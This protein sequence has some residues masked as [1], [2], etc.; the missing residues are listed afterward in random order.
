M[1]P[2]TLGIAL[3]VALLFLPGMA[4]GSRDLPSPG[5][6]PAD[7]I[8]GVPVILE[9]GA[10]VRATFAD[11]GNPRLPR[12]HMTGTLLEMKQE[13]LQLRVDVNGRERLEQVSFNDLLRLEV[14][15][16]KT[17]TTRGTVLGAL[18]GALLGLAG[19]SI[20][21]SGVEGD[22]AYGSGA[23]IGAAIGAGVGA[24]MGHRSTTMEWRDVP[25]YG[26]AYCR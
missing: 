8:P 5:V 2:I 21:A 17:L 10:P 1:R 11:C 7:T 23:A 22:A 24:L 25:L 13:A 16:P 18:G 19:T 15:T 9:I 3:A 4:A 12:N 6:A 14:G 20:G 26:D